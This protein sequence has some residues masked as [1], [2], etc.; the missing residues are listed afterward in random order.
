MWLL[1][2]LQ[3]CIGDVYHHIK[4]NLNITLDARDRDRLKTE[5][6]ILAIYYVPWT[7]LPTRG[8]ASRY[9][10]IALEDPLETVRE[11]FLSTARVEFGSTKFRFLGVQQFPYPLGVKHYAIEVSK[12][13]RVFG[14][15]LVLDFQTTGWALDVWG[16]EKSWQFTMTNVDAPALLAYTARARLVDLGLEKVLW[17][18]NC[19]AHTERHTARE[20]VANQ[21]ELLKIKRD[22]VAAHCAEQLIESFLEK[23]PGFDS[24]PPSSNSS[25]S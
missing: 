23:P 14:S 25:P 12:L 18:A 21:H 24:K 11:Q 8:D 10:P 15:G 9:S 1:G 17:Q 13:T 2:P 5:S 6:E 19:Y 22:E 7:S 4:S 20:W 16:D 3:G